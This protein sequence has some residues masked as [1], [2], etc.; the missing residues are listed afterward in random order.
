MA[1]K[2]KSNGAGKFI[3]GAALGALAGAIAGKFIST[4]TTEDEEE[5]CDKDCKC[6]KECKCEKA[7]E[8]KKS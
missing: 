4:K 2:K 5:I 3:L 8:P 6:E 1:E 7:A